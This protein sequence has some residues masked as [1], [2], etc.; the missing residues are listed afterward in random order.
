MIQE[1]KYRG[2]LLALLT[3]ILLYPTLRL[4]LPSRSA[5]DLLAGLVF[6][7]AAFAIF[8]RPRSRVLALVLGL[9]AILATW[10]SRGFAGP[11]SVPAAMAAHC[12]SAIFLSFTVAFIVTSIYAEKAVTIDGVCG[13]LCGYMLMALVFSH[14]YCVIEL[15]HP[16]SFRLGETLDPAHADSTAH[17]Q[18]T[19]F[20]LITQATVGYGDIVPVGEVARGFAAV[21]AVVGQFYMAVLIAD[22]I[23]KRIA[24]MTGPTPGPKGPD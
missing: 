6:L 22:L 5:F 16:G 24:Q 1:W 17:F 14:A 3:L 20:S 8:N 13:S 7:A 12:V 10:G 21:Q 15:A 4:A 9:P 18:L 23:G 2:L 19:Y 11:A